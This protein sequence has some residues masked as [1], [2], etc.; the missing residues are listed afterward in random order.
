RPPSHTQPL[1]LHDAL[2]ICTGSGCH[3]GS[4]RVGLPVA[5]QARRKAPWP[6]VRAPAELRRRRGKAVAAK[7][8]H[9]RSGEVT[10]DMWGGGVGPD[11][12]STRLNSS[13]QIISYG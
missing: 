4:N 10:G 8:W 13:H 1:P 11:R 9:D 5:S 12:K 3:T 7:M 6:G 2:P